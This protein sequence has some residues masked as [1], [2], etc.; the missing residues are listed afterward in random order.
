[1][2]QLLSMIV[3][4]GTLAIITFSSCTKEDPATASYFTVQLFSPHSATCEFR[5]CCQ[6]LG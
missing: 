2:K 3:I 6:Q 1:M 5:A 4:A